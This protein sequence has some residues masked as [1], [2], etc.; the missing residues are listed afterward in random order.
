MYA[1]K[2]QVIGI[3]D[4]EPF[5]QGMRIYGEKILGKYEDIPKLM[6][7]H[8]IGL[9]IVGDH[10]ISAQDH[11]TIIDACRSPGVRLVNVPDIMASLNGM[12]N[13]PPGGSQDLIGESAK[14][15]ED[16]LS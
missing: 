1:N 13:D 7:S 2:F 6:K 15:I 11:R 12:V 5:D 8:D 16:P 4:N 9:V 3:V 14:E 10:N